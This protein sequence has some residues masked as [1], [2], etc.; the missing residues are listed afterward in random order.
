MED[1]LRK[2]IECPTISESSNKDI[3]RY[4]D[5][6]LKKFNV[7]GQLVQGAKNQFNY[8]CVIGPNKDGV[9][10]FQDIQTLFLSQ[11]IGIQILLLRQ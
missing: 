1:I 9:S 6:Y 2:L 7:K 8:H 11:R 10:F 5:G 4:I 3:I